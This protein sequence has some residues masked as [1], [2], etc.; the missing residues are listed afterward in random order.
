MTS[1]CPYVPQ[2][3]D[4]TNMHCRQPYRRA[5]VG[6]EPRSQSAARVGRGPLPEHCTP[7]YIF[8][9]VQ[10]PDWGR[11]NVCSAPHP[12]RLSSG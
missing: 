11:E 5:R 1:A 10:A 3:A 4:C 2:F 9:C 8:P 7:L 12:G 6:P